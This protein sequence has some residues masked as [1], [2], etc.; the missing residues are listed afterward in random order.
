M[1]SN[2]VICLYGDNSTIQLPFYG[3]QTFNHNPHFIGFS[4]VMFS[5]YVL[6]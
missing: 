3:D 4:Q 2:Q 5:Q 6:C 1:K